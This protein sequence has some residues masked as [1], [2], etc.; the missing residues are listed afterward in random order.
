MPNTIE[1]KC[2]NIK[3]RKKNKN[4][5]TR[6]VTIRIDKKEFK[7]IKDICDYLGITPSFFFRWCAYYSAKSIKKNAKDRNRCL[8]LMKNKEKQ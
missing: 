8:S 5:Y 4:I 7:F 1:I 2:P 3:F 6:I